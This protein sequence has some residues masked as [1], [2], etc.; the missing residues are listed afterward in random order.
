[1]RR[2]IEV[3]DAAPLMRENEEDVEDAERDSRDGEEIDRGQLCRVVFQKCS[4]GL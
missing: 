2:N 4:P 3:N 1:M